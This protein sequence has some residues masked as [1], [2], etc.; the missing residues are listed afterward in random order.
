M[1]YSPALLTALSISDIIVIIILALVVAGIVV[2][3]IYDKKHGK[4]CSCGCGSCAYSSTCSKDKANTQ[5][6]DQ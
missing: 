5:Q 3:M 6:N 1:K 2:K 4:K